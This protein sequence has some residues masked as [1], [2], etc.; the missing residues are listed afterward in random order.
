[1]FAEPGGCVFL[2]RGGGAGV[3][4][5]YGGGGTDSGER[6]SRLPKPPN[7]II[8]IPSAMCKLVDTSESSH[9]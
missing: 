7:S 8:H 6:V 9:G 5:V 3:D 2:Y 4:R 1:M